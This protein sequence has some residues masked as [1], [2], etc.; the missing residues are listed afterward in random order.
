MYN[1]KRPGPV[2]R[3]LK[4]LDSF[5]C[6]DLGF[7][8]RSY[9]FLIVHLNLFFSFLLFIWICSFIFSC[10]SRRVFAQAPRKCTAWRYLIICDMRWEQHEVHMTFDDM[11]QH[12]ITWRKTSASQAMDFPAF[13]CVV[14]ID[15]SLM[16]VFWWWLVSM[17]F[18]SFI[19]FIFDLFGDI[20]LFSIWNA[21]RIKHSSYWFFISRW[22]WWWS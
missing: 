3:L 4:L 9:D 7:R 15:W 1:Y 2:F 22:K 20:L 16:A 11:T 12:D 10:F 5:R 14:L 8:S 18:P 17:W 21:I 13:W 6:R 19:R